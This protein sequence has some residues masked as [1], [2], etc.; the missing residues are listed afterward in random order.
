MT[1]DFSSGGAG[2]VA[3]LVARRRY[4]KAIAAL[5]ARFA[6]RHPSP[7]ARLRL[8]DILL[9]AGKGR[10]AVPV[11]LGLADEFAADGFTTK[12]VAILKR[13]EK[14]EPGR[15]DV[16]ERI[17][18]LTRVPRAG[19]GEGPAQA[20]GSREIGMEVIAAAPAADQTAGPAAVV[21]EDLSPEAFKRQLL[22]LVEDLLHGPAAAPIQGLSS[23]PPGS[24]GATIPS[25]LP[26]FGGL[27]EA[28][29]LAAIGAL[30]FRGAEV[31]DILATESE[32]GERVFLVCGGVL[33]AYARRP[34]GGHAETRRVEETGAFGQIAALSGRPEPETIV[35]SS[36]CDLLELDAAALEGLS[37]DHP[38]VREAVLAYH[39]GVITFAGVAPR[40][41]APDPA[42]MD[43]LVAVVKESFHGGPAFDTSARRMPRHSAALLPHG[44]GVLACP[45]FASLEEKELLAVLDRCP[46]SMR[47]PGELLLFD[48]QPVHRLFVVA[49]GGLRLFVRNAAGRSLAI[50]H[51]GPGGFVGE[52]LVT[53]GPHTIVTVAAPTTLVELDEPTID[54]IA[55]S[56]PDLREILALTAH[57]RTEQVAAVL[58]PRRIV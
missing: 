51:L 33:K 13:V 24:G 54:S 37:Q 8:A 10:E 17:A 49:T 6:G 40:A 57:L 53:G 11:L 3:D 19:T 55:G 56:H 5:R 4:L 18:S 38:A 48:D 50:A 26:L 2:S 29:Q 42:S 25:A 31:G 34:A 30:R 32:A 9:L 7:A 35:A 14:I 43:W 20:A 1:G 22:D 46:V 23:S 27:S 58:S 16:I 52:S 44:E 12:T 21:D 45:L 15:R 36:P 41:Q 39:A 47:E 28:D